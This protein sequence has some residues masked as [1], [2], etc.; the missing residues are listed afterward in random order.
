M[1]ILTE[2]EIK[3]PVRYE[4]YKEGIEMFKKLFRG[5]VSFVRYL[6]YVGNGGRF[7]RDLCS[8]Y[9]ESSFGW[10]WPTTYI[11]GGGH[12][13]LDPELRDK[14]MMLYVETVFGWGSPRAGA[15][16]EA[17]SAM[18]KSKG[19]NQNFLCIHMNT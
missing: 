4:D 13:W 9:R 6:F 7:G 1:D 5:I 2:L 12:C 3:C 14:T 8:L 18:E 15:V 10:V 17:S 16:G 11:R 19:Q